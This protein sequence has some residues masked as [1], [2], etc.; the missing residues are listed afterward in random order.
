MVGVKERSGSGE[1]RMEK[2]DEVDAKAD[3][4]YV[5]LF[6]MDWVD[7]LECDVKVVFLKYRNQLEFIKS[8]NVAG[9]GGDK[10]SDIEKEID[11]MA[12]GNTY[13]EIAGKEVGSDKK[14]TKHEEKRD[15]E[16]L[17]EVLNQQNKLAKRVEE[18]ERERV[19]NREV[20]NDFKMVYELNGQ[21]S[22]IDSRMERHEE[23][24]KKLENSVSENGHLIWRID[25]FE[26]KNKHTMR[27]DRVMS[28]TSTRENSDRIMSA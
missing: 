17:E 3:K 1:E 13:E 23:R 5:K 20:Q 2:N 10:K 12:S 4:E 28:F 22:E 19:R 21:Q 27:C 14:E 9:Y 25:N 7:I 24:L 18:I 8:M 6:R 26:E 16:I 11:E 15:K